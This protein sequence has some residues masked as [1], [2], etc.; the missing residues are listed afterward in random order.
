[1]KREPPG[2]AGGSNYKNNGRHLLV[3]AIIFS[4]QASG[5]PFLF[6]GN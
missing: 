4:F 6:Y 5:L 1:M 2:V 3:S